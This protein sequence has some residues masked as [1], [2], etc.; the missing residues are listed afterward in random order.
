MSGPTLSVIVPNYNHARYLPVSLQAVLD[1]SYR[2]CELI[3]ADDGSTDDSVEVIEAFAK[4]DS[5]VR[6]LRN[7]RNLGVHETVRRLIDAASGEYLYGA[8]ADDMVL[9]GMFE[10]LMGLLA[11]HPSAGLAVARA[12]LMDADW[13][14]A[15]FV[16]GRV[17]SPSPCYVSQAECLRL[18]RA[19]GEWMPGVSTIFKRSA[20][21]EAG[22]YRPELGVFVD[23]LLQQVI[24]LRHGV[25][26]SP[27][28][29]ARFR[30][31]TTGYSATQVVD[32]DRYLANLSHVTTLMRTE[33][34]D[35]FPEDYVRRQEQVWLYWAG[36]NAGGNLADAQRR[37]IVYLQ[38]S[39]APTRWLDRIVIGSLSLCMRL[40]LRF[41]RGYLFLRLRRLTLETLTGHLG[42]A[43][44]RIRR[45]RPVGTT[46]VERES[47]P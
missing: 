47:I 38:R 18:L 43:A 46:G 13:N 37:Y 22:S 5:R 7:E 27:E 32:V 36:V 10:Q 19:H 29:L 8:G 45:A 33:Y 23:G 26:Y 35:A 6:L 44:T 4:K 31:T 24:A 28:P 16:L 11:A 42:R 34:K 30:Q 9:P 1:Q 15:D 39:L 21:L 20:L 40:Q 25:C 3:V 17:I 14:D 41:L 2:C 12:R